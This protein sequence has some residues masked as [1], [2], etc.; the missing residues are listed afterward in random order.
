VVQD[1]TGTRQVV[2]RRDANA[3]ICDLDLSLCARRLELDV[4]LPEIGKRTT[5]GIPLYRYE[6][7]QNNS[8]RPQAFLMGDFEVNSSV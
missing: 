4:C 3:L 1:L 8:D 6:A 7:T 5:Y 2:G